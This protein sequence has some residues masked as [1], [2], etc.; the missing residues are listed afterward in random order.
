MAMLSFFM[1]VPPMLPAD[2]EHDAQHVFPRLWVEHD[3]VGKHAAIPTD[4][5]HGARGLSA[6]IAQPG[7][8]VAH[9]IELAVGVV[10]RAVPA[11][12]VVGTLAL[13]CAVVLGDVK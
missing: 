10:R 7:G 2:R 11:G 9:D 8:G 12:F 13:H 5:L 4:V 3:G 6:G 1:S